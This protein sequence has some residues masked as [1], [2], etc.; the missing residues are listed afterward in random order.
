MP[1]TIGIGPGDDEEVAMETNNN[2][3]DTKPDIG[4]KK[5]YIDST[6]LGVPRENVDMKSPLKDGLSE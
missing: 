6:V 3:A 4:T 1:T 2:S 5:Y